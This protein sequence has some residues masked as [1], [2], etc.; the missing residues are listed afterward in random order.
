MSSNTDIDICVE[1][2]ENSHGSASV[3]YVVPLQVEV[4]EVDGD[5]VLV[6]G[7]DLPHAVLVGRVEVRE[8]RA[9]QH[10]FL[11]V[12]VTSACVWKGTKTAVS[13]R[14]FTWGVVKGSR[15]EGEGV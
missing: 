7:H 3:P 15:E 14:R 12:D 8:R 1:E 13:Q 6:P 9:L 10:A 5:L 11:F 2:K 4:G